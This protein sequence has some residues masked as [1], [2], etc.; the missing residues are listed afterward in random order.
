V[1]AR[2]LNSSD[3]VCSGRV[4]EKRAHVLH[5]RAAGGGSQGAAPAL[6]RL[7]P[8]QAAGGLA[9]APGG[10]VSGSCDGGRRNS[11]GV[12]ACEGEGNG[13]L[14]LQMDPARAR[15]GRR[16]WSSAGVAARLAEGAVREDE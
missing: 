2:K 7:G 9:E 11:R 6:G 14:G 4:R 10:G 1:H 16:R 3:A 15:R 8:T 13:V 5:Y 12:D